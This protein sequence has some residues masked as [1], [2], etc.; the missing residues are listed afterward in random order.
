MTSTTTSDP[1]SKSSSSEG[2]K[3][4]KLHKKGNNKNKKPKMTKEERRV[5][6]TNIA[7]EKRQKQFQKKKHSN[8]VCF[9][10]RK[11]GHSVSECPNN[12]TATSEQGSDGNTQSNSVVSKKAS[13]TSG[14]SI[15]YRC[16]SNDHSLK[17]CP[18][19]TKEEKQQKGKLNYHKMDLPF[20]TCFICHQQGHL[21]SQCQLNDHGIYVNSSNGDNSVRGC[22]ICGKNDHLS[23]HCPET[24]KR[25]NDDDD[26]DDDDR[27]AG[28]VD[29]FLEKDDH[30]DNYDSD[31]SEVQAEDTATE[32]ADT[33]KS[34]KQQRKKKKIVR[35]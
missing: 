9:Q 15:C 21:S 17:A 30:N 26:D 35:F 8:T 2:K 6:Y 23:I 10:C 5:K 29:E 34:N 31:N 14:N 24:S 33:V 3:K 13:S 32:T 12:N 1:A 27:S 19:L 25:K 28:N 18:K 22:K 7:R 4:Q 11:K 16:G 20:A